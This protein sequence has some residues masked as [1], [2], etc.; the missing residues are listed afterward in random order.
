M[1]KFFM[2]LTFVF[3]GFLLTACLQNVG[4]DTSFT[5]LSIDDIKD[6]TTTIK[7]RVRSG[8]VNTALEDLVP[9][10]EQE[11]PYIKVELDPLV[12]DYDLIRS[13]TILA[14]NSKEKSNIPDILIGYPDHFAEY[15]GGSNLVNLSAFI[16]DSKVGYTQEELDDFLPSYLAENRG[17]DVNNPN[18]LFGMPFNKSTEVLIYNKTAF[19]A[20]FGETYL[21]KVPTTW[22]KLD[23]VGKEIVQKVKAGDLDTTFV[24]TVDA[25]TGVKTYLKVSD[26]LKDGKQ[27][28][29][30]FG[31]DS[32]GN[33]FITLTKHFGGKY[34]QRESVYKGYIYFDNPESRAAMTYFQEMRQAGVFGNAAVFGG[35][36]NS[37]AMKLLQVL[38]SVGSSAGVGYNSSSKYDYDLGVA[39]IPYYSEDAKY[40]IQQG[41]N[42]GML[43]QHSDERKLASWL[44]IKFLLRPE[45]TAKFAMAT[46]GYLPVRKSAYLTDEYEEYLADPTDDKKEHSAA[47]NV[48]LNDYIQAGFTFFV[49]DAF[50]GSSTV[51]T[52]VGRVFDSIIVKE[53]NVQARF[54][55]AYNTL[56][57]YNP[58]K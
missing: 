33:G 11:Y 39:P 37:D 27:D 45:N 21:T 57:P 6:Q 7:F 35:S 18:D 38:M 17:F 23:T 8:I 30:P 12:G 28:F 51:R 13:E 10:F 20:L 25:E 42:I 19:E 34:T 9:E 50:I 29:L 55:A 47:A 53:E 2:V 46:G 5:V 4:R 26:Y 24:D 58:P 3:M 1:K 40:V 31:Y 54:T 56:K 41:T 44:F 48:A 15:Y 22:D 16:E 14:I 36:Y 43:S 52:E 32:S 49:D